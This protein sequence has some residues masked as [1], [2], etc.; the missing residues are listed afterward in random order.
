MV[1]KHKSVG[2]GCP[3]CQLSCPPWQNIKIKQVREGDLVSIR[4]GAI[5]FGGKPTSIDLQ[6]PSVCLVK[7]SLPKDGDFVFLFSFSSW[8]F[9]WVA[10]S[11]FIC[12][13][14]FFLS[15]LMKLDNYFLQTKAPSHP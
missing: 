1:M 9:L 2:M 13:P 11:F 15:F 4:L 3:N 5:C 7:I 12:P 10:Y 6:K 8:R 14:F